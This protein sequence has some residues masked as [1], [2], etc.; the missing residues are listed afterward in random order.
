MEAQGLVELPYA[1]LMTVFEKCEGKH[2]I[3]FD[4]QG[5]VDSF[6]SYK[7]KLNDFFLLMKK[8]NDGSKTKEEAL[9]KLR[10]DVVQSM[11]GF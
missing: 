11:G 3:V 1:E 8:V 4:K 5:A 6:L 9:E 7:G 2:M 10:F